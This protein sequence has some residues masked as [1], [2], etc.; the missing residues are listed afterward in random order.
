MLILLVG[1]DD[2]GPDG[3]QDMGQ[4]S[5]ALAEASGLAASVA[6]PGCLWTLND[7][8]NPAEVFLIDSLAQTKI[9]CEL[10]GIRNRDWEDIAVG[11]GPDSTRKYVYVADIG[12]NNASHQFKYIYRFEEPVQENGEKQTVSHV[13]RFVITL[14]DGKRDSE[15]MMLDPVTSD[16]YLISK[17]EDNVHVYY[18]SYPFQTD[19]LKMERV[20]TLPLTLI[21]AGSI[22]PDGQQV[23]LKDYK[24]IYFWK[25]AGEK[26]LVELLAKAP[27]Q[28]PYEG[29]HQG[30]AISWNATATGFY[31]LSESS[32]VGPRANLKYYKHDK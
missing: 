16:M 18:S 11:S 30:E 1:C 31:T 7:S 20:L 24:H 13:D 5:D 32:L 10:P 14:P 9:V 22:S 28:I 23:L 4:V 8:G 17:R 21:V 19:T 26:T 2:S 27:K 12:D 3:H 15:T 25:R 29:E 6:N